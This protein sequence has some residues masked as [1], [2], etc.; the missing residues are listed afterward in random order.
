MKKLHNFYSM[1]VVKYNIDEFFLLITFVIY[2]FF[3]VSH[4][5]KWKELK[6]LDTIIL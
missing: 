3:N 1:K 5:I 4:K 6:G 2:I